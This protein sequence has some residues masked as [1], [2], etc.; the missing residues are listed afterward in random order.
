[1]LLLQFLNGAMRRVNLAPEDASPI[2]QCRVN[3]KFAFVECA[4]Q[5]DANLVLKLNGI[6]F[7][8]ASLKVSR[9]SKYTGPFVPTQSWQELTGKRLL[10]WMG[11]G[12]QDQP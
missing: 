8:G 10:A 12:G 5:Q 2:V 11:G 7:L 4:N 3:A 6:P 9:P 1:M